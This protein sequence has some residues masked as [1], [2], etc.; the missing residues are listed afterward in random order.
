[1]REPSEAAEC[2]ALVAWMRDNKIVFLHIPNE[3]RRSPREGA[4][5]KALGLRAG[6]PDYLV[7]S[8]TAKAPHG[9]WIEMKRR[10]GG[11]RGQ[12]QIAW[13]AALRGLGWPGD[14]CSGA[15]AAVTMLR[16]LGYVRPGERP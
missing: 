11:T 9:C 10:D 2:I 1:M 12:L 15:A 16:A 7:L 13:A 4:R 3:G 5:L 6:C 8:Q 14:F